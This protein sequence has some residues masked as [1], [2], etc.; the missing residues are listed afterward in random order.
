MAPSST[1]KQLTILHFNDVYN[2]DVSNKQE[3]VGGA[4][5]FVYAV[6]QQK[7]AIQQETGHEPLVLFSGDC[8]NP[9]LMS[10][11]TLGKQMIPVLNALGLAA[12]CVGN[13]DF[14]WGLDTFTWV[15]PAP[16]PAH[17]STTAYACPT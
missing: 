5:R 7:Q 12:A 9:S 16:T 4:A 17:L 8:F 3:P 14:D 1:T 15:E 6:Q 11:S 13:H 10:V 2:V